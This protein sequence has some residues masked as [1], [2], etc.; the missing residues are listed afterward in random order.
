MLLDLELSDLSREQVL[1]LLIALVVTCD[2]LRP[3]KNIYSL[4]YGFL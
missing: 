3:A 2:I 4:L 1:V